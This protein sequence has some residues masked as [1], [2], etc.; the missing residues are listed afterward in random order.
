MKLLSLDV[1]HK[2]ASLIKSFTG[3]NVMNISSDAAP[4]PGSFWTSG[5]DQDRPGTYAWCSAHKLFYKSKWA[6]GQP[7]ASA[8][9]QCVA[10]KL[11][12]TTAQLETVECAGALKFICEVILHFLIQ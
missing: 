2:Y 12:A 8:Q 9:A 7:A 4:S 10:V 3:K 6:Q 1:E 5:T 11:D